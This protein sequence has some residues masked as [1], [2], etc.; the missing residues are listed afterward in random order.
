MQVSRPSG[1]VR[2]KEIE[3]VKQAD[4]F[5]V[6]QTGTMSSLAWLAFPLDIITHV[7]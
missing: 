7:A 5:K 2:V 6:W 3:D 4:Y 1:F